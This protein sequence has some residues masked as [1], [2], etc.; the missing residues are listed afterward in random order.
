MT[1]S[2]NY[3]EIRLI[4]IW[5]VTASGLLFLIRGSALLL[6]VRWPRWTGLRFLSYTIDTTL[7]TAALMLTTIIQQYPF[8]D[9]WLTVKIALLIV[10]I[11]LGIAALKR[12]Q[13]PKTR[14]WC[15]VAALL[16]YAYIIGVAL[17]HHPLG[18]FTD[19]FD[20]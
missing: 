11:A 1:L 12:D 17:A 5:A 14:L 19:L 2:S 18:F 9:G 16:V 13:A 3:P 20:L 15:F 7:L 4:H 8:V 6:G 10:Y